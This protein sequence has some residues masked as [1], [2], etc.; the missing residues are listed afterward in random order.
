MNKLTHKKNNEI[1]MAFENIPV[2]IKAAARKKILCSARYE[3]FT[4]TE[5]ESWIPNSVEFFRFFDHSLQDDDLAR[6]D[7]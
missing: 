3:N 4:D 5:G 6:L 7:R 2:I 1:M